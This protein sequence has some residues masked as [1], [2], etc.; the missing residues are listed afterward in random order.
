M[1]TPM[2]LVALSPL[3]LSLMISIAFAL[4]ARLIAQTAD[5]KP[6]LHVIMEDRSSAGATEL[7]TERA[8]A[9]Y[10]FR[11][12]GIRVSWTTRSEALD[13]D[14]VGSDRVHLVILDGRGAAD[15]FAGNGHVLGFAIPSASR[16]STGIGRKPTQSAAILL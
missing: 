16:K 12:A 14:H 6:T 1:K 11:D 7:G 13:I 15:V 10:I 2:A 4:S 3:R 8:R 5:E 9:A